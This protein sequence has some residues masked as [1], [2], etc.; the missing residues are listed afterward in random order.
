MAIEFQVII[1]DK[2]GTLAGLGSALGEV[3]VN[4]EAIHGISLEGKSVVHFVL[5]DPDATGR[6]LDRIDVGRDVVRVAATHSAS[7]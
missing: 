7:R 3:G 4:I 6:A 2:P 5:S 1:E